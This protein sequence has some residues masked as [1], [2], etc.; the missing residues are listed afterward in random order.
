MCKSHLQ[1]TWRCRSENT[2]N[3]SAP[4]R[5]KLHRWR[6]VPTSLFR[7]T[8]SSFC[9][10]FF[11][12]PPGPL[13]CLVC[14]VVF[15]VHLLCRDCRGCVFCREASSLLC[16]SLT[17]GDPCVSSRTNNETRA[18]IEAAVCSDNINAH[19]S[20]SWTQ[21]QTPAGSN[22]IKIQHYKRLIYIK[23]LEG[24]ANNNQ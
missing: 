12:C 19:P 14:I 24:R 6:A 1:V 13:Y 15:L 8:T 16:A 7:E 4:K 10:L 17:P 11:S 3:S 5:L 20:L 21:T 2:E 18:V 23:Y 9:S 22:A